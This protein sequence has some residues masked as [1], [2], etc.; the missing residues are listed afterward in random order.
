[1]N[2]IIA[3][4]KYRPAIKSALIDLTAV[5][6][7]YFT[8]A[9]SHLINLPVYLIEPVRLMLILS[10]AH[11]SKTNTFILA[12]SLPLFSHL[13]SAHPVFLKTVLI[14]FELVIFSYLF[15]ELSKKYKSVFTVM[16]VSIAAG[17]FFYYIFKYI[18]ISGG[19]IQSELISTPLLMQLIITVIFS[20][21]VSFSLNR[22][23]PDIYKY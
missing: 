2:N 1:M 10:I 19:L 21:Y 7:I 22:N 5:L 20:I 11:S 8:P 23:K 3:L 9:L 12:L 15:F 16:F 13:I 14:S 17:K 6:L 4:P 18:L